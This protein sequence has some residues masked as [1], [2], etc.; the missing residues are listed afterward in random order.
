MCRISQPSTV[1]ARCFS[2]SFSRAPLCGGRPTRPHAD[3]TP[4][5]G[6]DEGTWQAEIARPGCIFGVF[7]TWLVRE[8]IKFAPKSMFGLRV[9]D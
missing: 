3:F 4:A 7:G 5:A 9:L 2:S 6:A 8:T 1:G